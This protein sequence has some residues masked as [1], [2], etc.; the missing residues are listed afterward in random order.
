MKNQQNIGKKKST[1]YYAQ[2]NSAK[3]LL[4]WI[5]GVACALLSI[6]LITSPDYIFNTVFDGNKIAIVR[7]SVVFITLL[8]L[9]AFAIRA[10]SKY[11]FSS[12]HL[13][14]DAEERHTLTFFYLSLL[15][16][17]EVKDDDRKL[18]LQSL[19]SRA[20]TGLLKDESGPTMPSDISSK[21]MG[22]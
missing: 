3:T 18:I 21:L 22:K 9:I 13:A 8:S 15:K 4:Y 12:F 11:M 10:L 5:V 2:G 17:T 16:D 1:N 7:W 20:E 19:F 6:I 14:R